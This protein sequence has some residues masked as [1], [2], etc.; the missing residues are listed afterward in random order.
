MKRGK[1]MRFSAASFSAGDFWMR[2]YLCA[3][4]VPGNAN[5]LGKRQPDEIFKMLLSHFFS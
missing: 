4:T 1:G 2:Y 3:Q 5:R